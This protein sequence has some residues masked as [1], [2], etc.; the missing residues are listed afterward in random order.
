MP[1]GNENRG[2]GWQNV[3]FLPTA[4]IQ[5]GEVCKKHRK[6]HTFRNEV[7]NNVRI[8]GNKDKDSVGEEYAEDH[9]RNE[10]GGFG[11]ASQGSGCHRQQTSV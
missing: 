7:E 3:A 2:S 10:D 4:I 6:T 8:E 5:P 11:E 1:T 9:V